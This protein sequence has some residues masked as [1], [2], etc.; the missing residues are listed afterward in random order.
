M[1][2]VEIMAQSARKAA[3]EMAAVTTKKKNAA[4]Q[5]VAKALKEKTRSLLEANARDVRLAAS[6]GKNAAFI[7]RLSITSKTVQGM[8]ESLQQVI[9]LP[10]PVGIVLEK[11]TLRSKL[12]LTKVSVPIGVIG[13]IYES[14]P[15]VTIE[16]AALCTKS[17]NACILRG[18]S[19]ALHSNMFLYGL[20]KEAFAGLLPTNTVQYLSIPGHE[21]VDRLLGMDK[22]IDLIIPRGGY[23]LIE[24]VTKKS[25]IP[26]LKHYQGIC[27][28]YIDKD[29]DVATA[30]TVCV[31]AKVNRPATCNAAECFLV[32][33][34]V[35][36]QVLPLLAKQLEKYHVEI[37]GC[38]RTKAFIECKRASAKD[39]DTEF[40]DLVVAIK[41]VDSVEEAIDFINL[42]GTGHSEAIISRKKSTQKL[43]TQMVDAAAVYVNASTRFT[44]GFEFGLGAEIGISTQKL[45]ARGP[46]AL[47]ELTSY[48][49]ILWGNGQVRG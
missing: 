9:S 21:A 13:M 25:R 15:N 16:A 10:D 20:M 29:A 3:L 19:D 22:Y 45:H 11:R 6:A 42:H 31:N 32:H 46:V 30:I 48:K 34:S 2:E 49:Y 1:D 8:I 38:E 44:D 23:S 47:K 5:A 24:A 14:R 41:I 33:S 7:D 12:L 43:F 28:V 40:L 17:S 26:V 4:L 18:G 27:H 36:A 39:W 35:A 37:R